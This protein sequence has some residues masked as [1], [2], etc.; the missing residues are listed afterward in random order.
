MNH[1][2]DEQITSLITQLLP[3]LHE[4]GVRHLSLFSDNGAVYLHHGPY[5]RETNVRGDTIGEALTALDAA[6]G[7]QRLLETLY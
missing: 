1:P 7:D 6:L 5:N 2:L 3:L 4:R